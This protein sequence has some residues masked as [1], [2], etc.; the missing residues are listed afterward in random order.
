[1][2]TRGI[3]YTHGEIHA[4]L[5]GRMVSCVPTRNGAIAAA[6]FSNIV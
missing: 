1:M 5:G 2:F 6:Y 3:T 4:Q